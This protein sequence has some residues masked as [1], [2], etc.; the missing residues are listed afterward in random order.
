MVN[1]EWE[2]LQRWE[3][4]VESINLEEKLFSAVILDERNPN[5]PREEVEIHFEEI[6][7]HDLPLITTGAVFYWSI[8]YET[9]IGGQKKRVSVIRFK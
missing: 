3:G 9:E 1:K 7:D 8:G 2:V 6:S 5:N 4:Y